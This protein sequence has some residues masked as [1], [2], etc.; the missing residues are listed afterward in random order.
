[1][2]WNIDI[3][4]NKINC[5]VKNFFI[6]KHYRGFLKAHTSWCLLCVYSLYIKFR[7]SFGKKPFSQFLKK[8]RWWNGPFNICG[9]ADIGRFFGQDNISNFVRNGQRRDC[10]RGD[11]GRIPRRY[12]IGNFKIFGRFGSGRLFTLC[13]FWHFLHT[14]EVG[15]LHLEKQSEKF[16]D[17]WMAQFGQ[18]F[19]PW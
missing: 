8:F 9:W 14:S 17:L 5:V 4:R 10:R 18:D 13:R 11:N 19:C 7:K 2:G 3:W 12:Q 1:M 16:S 6:Y 15:F